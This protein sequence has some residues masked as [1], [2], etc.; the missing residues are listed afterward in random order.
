MIIVTTSSRY[1][2]RNAQC[3]LSATEIIRPLLRRA[4]LC[5]LAVSAMLTT[6]ASA[7]SEAYPAL[8]RAVDLYLAGEDE[9][10]VDL[11]LPL[12]EAG[13]PDAGYLLVDQF[14]LRNSLRRRINQ[15]GPKKVTRQYLQQAQKR[16]LEEAAESGHYGAMLAYTRRRGIGPVTPSEIEKRFR[17]LELAASRGDSAAVARLGLA[18]LGA[19]ASPG[20][21]KADP[22]RGI[23]MLEE[24]W[25]AG[26]SDVLYIFPIYRV[27]L[28]IYLADDKSQERAPLFSKKILQG[29]PNGGFP[30]NDSIRSHLAKLSHETRQAGALKWLYVARQAD[31]NNLAVAERAVELEDELSETRQRQVREDLDGLISKRMKLWRDSQEGR[32]QRVAWLRRNHPDLFQNGDSVGSRVDPGAWCHPPKIEKVTIKNWED[33]AAFES[34]MRSMVAI[35]KSTRSSE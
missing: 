32:E 26:E 7:R 5:I 16:W 22:G 24:A 6:S 18:N 2:S 33:S 31:P 12:A 29:V 34:C 23:A 30:I 1:T 4:V 25:A 15:E 14:R 28:D 27:L 20:E 9:K 17:W 19:I 21:Y 3:C 13:D 10:A 11:L 35:S 8:N